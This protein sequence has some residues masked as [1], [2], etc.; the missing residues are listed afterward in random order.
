[1]KMLHI[2]RVSVHYSYGVSVC[3][4]VPGRLETR[5]VDFILSFLRQGRDLGGL[6]RRPL[7]GVEAV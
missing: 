5:V 6:R 3:L 1:M 7:G 4:F 2:S